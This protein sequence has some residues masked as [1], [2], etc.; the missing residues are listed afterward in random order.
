[1]AALT[2]A[3]DP[4]LA[5]KPRDELEAERDAV[6]QQLEEIKEQIDDVSAALKEAYIAIE[7]TKAELPLAEKTLAEAT[8]RYTKAR[9]SY[10]AV[11]SRL[12]SAKKSKHA[13]ESQI[14]AAQ[15]AV[16]EAKRSLGEVA[17]EAVV[18]G[19]SVPPSIVL[20]LGATSVRELDTSLLAVETLTRVRAR[21]LTRAQD[22]EALNKNREAK[23]IAITDIIASLKSEAKAI[24]SE[25]KA[26][27]NEAEDA[28]AKLDRLIAN[29]E[30]Q[31]QVLEDA[32]QQYLR[33]EEDLTR[34]NEALA[35][36][37]K[38]LA[39]E[40][41]EGATDGGPPLTTG[42]FG[43]PLASQVV[44]SPFGW[45]IHPILGYR[46]LHTGT[47]FSAPC[48]TPIYSSAA[49][50]VLSAGSQP[51]WGVRTV[52]SHGLMGGHS[53][54]STYNHQSRVVVSVDQT[55]ER[56]QLIGYVGTT[57]WSTGCHLHFEIYVDGGVVDPQ[58]YLGH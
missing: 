42:A 22:E 6:N 47:D 55:V 43:W 54:A 37:L 49:G 58:Q 34:E 17:R 53:L 44:S 50:K 5:K 26:S 1:M 30:T 18:G 10:Q 33:E 41:K 28:K 23:L 38:R 2:S 35:D 51:A 8:A 14:A 7:T 27:K 4:A 16:A 11:N 45:R 40:E 25:A 31:A 29:Q 39:N 32:R 56:G 15:E 21:A 52:I 13:V 3:A 57:G 19:G 24:L 20:L 46:K 48:G 12:K 36:E 9:S